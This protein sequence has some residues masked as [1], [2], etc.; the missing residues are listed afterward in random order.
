MRNHWGYMTTFFFAPESYYAT[1]GTNVYGDWNGTDGRAVN[2]L[3]DFIKTM[4][5][6]GIA[7][8]LDVVYNH[9]SNYD[10]NPLKYIDKE[11]YFRLDEKGEYIAQSGCGNDCR[12][13]SEAMRDLILESVLYWVREYHID[14]FRFDLGNL[15]DPITRQIILDKV[16]KVN[17]YAIILA[18]PWGGGYDPSGFSKMGW[19]S[20]NDQIRNGVKGQNPFD[21]L[22]F[23]FGKWQGD[24]SSASLKRYVMGSPVGY[25]GQYQSIT[26]SVNYLES[27]DDHTFGDFVRLGSGLVDENDII[28]DRME[29][30]IVSG[31]QLAMQK[32]G[33]MFLFTS[34]G[35]TF[36]HQG[37]EWGRSKIIAQTD[38]PDPAIGKIDHNSYEKDNETNWLNWDEKSA[39][40]DLVDYY[41]GLINL[42]KSISEFRWSNPEDFKFLDFGNATAVGYILKNKYIVLM[43]GE[44]QRQLNVQLPEGEWTVLA[45]AYS[46]NLSGKHKL[47]GSVTVDPISG[48]IL[49]RQ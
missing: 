48:L 21:G 3:K 30:A 18:E 39:N 44:Q 10:Y 38:V 27:H 47:S 16:R 43:N 35:I 37:Q 17:P 46:I 25:G 36:V 13:E 19:A 23:I 28:A 24:N 14:G 22:G 32:L 1:D 5:K 49:R 2:E 26:H 20:F 34:Q 4:H 12:T 40:S 33:A 42:R 29:N 11:L 41:R 45:D 8:I 6:N 31:P 7:V 15:I 9:V